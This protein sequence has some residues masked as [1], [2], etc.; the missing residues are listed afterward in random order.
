MLRKSVPLFRQA[1]QDD[2]PAMSRIRLSVTENILS[3]P[4]RVT[5][6]MYEDFLERSGRGWGAENG[7]EVVAFC[8]ANKDDASVWALFVRRDHEGR[9]LGKSLLKLAV[10]WL[11]EIGHEQV[12]LSTAA[13]TRLIGFMLHKAGVACGLADPKLLIRSQIFAD[14][15]EG[16]AGV[17]CVSLGVSRSAKSSESNMYILSDDP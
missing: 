11:F 2:I 16:R 3:D 8:Y 15:R 14:K 1:V 17:G 5:T 6:Q 13:G 7:G 12:H 4:S 9:G 10:D